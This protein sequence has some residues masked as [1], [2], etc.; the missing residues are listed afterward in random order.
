MS[1]YINFTKDTKLDKVQTYDTNSIIIEKL[2]KR[3]KEIIMK[4]VKQK[5]NTRK[6]ISNMKSEITRLTTQQLKL[7]SLLMYIYRHNPTM[8]V[9]VDDIKMKHFISWAEKQ[10]KQQKSKKRKLNDLL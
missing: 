6:K 7:T 9:N 1:K 2:E 8:G 3:N 4:L 10:T 5:V